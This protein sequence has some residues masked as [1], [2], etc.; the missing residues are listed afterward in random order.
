MTMIEKSLGNMYK[1]E[2]DMAAKQG[3]DPALFQYIGAAIGAM[4][5]DD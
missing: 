5:A 4:T 3:L 2:P 1:A